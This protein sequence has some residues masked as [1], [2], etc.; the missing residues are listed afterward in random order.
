MAPS[1]TSVP[2]RVNV[3]QGMMDQQT[4]SIS[5]SLTHLLAEI[6]RIF[7]EKPDTGGYLM[8]ELDILSRRITSLHSDLLS[9]CPIQTQTKPNSPA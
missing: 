7:S 3:V 1:V 6:Q 9:Y 4:L 2:S 8:T 5:T